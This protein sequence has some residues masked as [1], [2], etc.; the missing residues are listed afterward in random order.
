[1]AKEQGLPV[2][3]FDPHFFKEGAPLG[4]G[5]GSVTLMRNA[6]HPNAAKLYINWLLSREGQIVI[7]EEVAREGSGADSM[8]LDIPKKDIPPAYRRREGANY[9]FVA[10]PERTEMYPIYKLI[11]KA[12]ATREKTTKKKKK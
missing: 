6:P 9:L 8:R 12:L 2:D 1:M 11:N 3:E 4:I 5:A 7:Q 10:T